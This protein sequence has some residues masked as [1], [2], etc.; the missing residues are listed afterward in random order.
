MEFLR[1]Q[2]EERKNI[3]YNPN[4][5]GDL[6]LEWVI[7]LLDEMQCE[8]KLVDEDN[9]VWQCSNCGLE[10]QLASGSPKDNEMNCCPKCYF[11]IL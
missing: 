5:E 8:Y 10:W 3:S 11:K 1:N 2:I 4:N 6:A 7:S 9:N